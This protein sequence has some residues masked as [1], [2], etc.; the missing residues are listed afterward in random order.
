[1]QDDGIKREDDARKQDLLEL[2]YNVLQDA[3]RSGALSYCG[4][5]KVEAMIRREANLTESFVKSFQAAIKAGELT[6]L[7]AKAFKKGM[8]SKRPVIIPA[9]ATE[10]SWKELAEWL[11]QV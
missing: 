2:L 11:S 4:A 7:S 9:R 5:R 1:M 6:S 8:I 10:M 3:V